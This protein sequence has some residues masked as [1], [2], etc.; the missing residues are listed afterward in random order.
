MGSF[1]PNRSQYFGAFN[2]SKQSI[3]LDLKNPL[4]KRVAERLLAWA[5]ICL[6]S[7]TP[8]TMAGLGLDYESARRLN[9]SLIM[10]S[11]CLM[12][13]SGPA[14]ALAGYGFHAAAVSGFPELTGWPDRP[15][16]GPW[17]AYTDT[18]ANRFLAASI[19]AA[20]DHR[21]R[22]GRGQYI[23]QSQMESAL[24][25][26]TPQILEY[27]LG[28]VVPTRS[29]NDAPDAAPHNAYPCLGEDEWCA[30]AV[31]NDQQWQALCRVL[32]AAD[33]AASRE[34]AG[35][36][37]RIAHRQ[38]IDQRIAAW[39]SLM[40]VQEAM[41][42]LQAAG[43]PSGAVQRSSDLLAD[44][45]LLHRG[46]FR[47]FLHAEMGTVRYEG[48]QFRIRGYNSGPRSAAPCLGEHLIEVM[49]ELLGMSDDEIAEIAVSGALI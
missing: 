43:V 35:V 49:R 10:A 13:Q 16:S 33:L 46:F 9:P 28:G 37:G 22:T 48:H 29:G 19:M 24:H 7:F 2:T 25:F 38:A 3:A 27:Q 26:L 1:G 12:G 5:D 45:Q 31:E 34:L 15:P 18:I 47:S 39:T 23:E 30:I 6:E 17:A 20:L 40:S 44:P 8:G 41:D 32:D 11:T 42:R 14:A 21:R 4:G 36:S